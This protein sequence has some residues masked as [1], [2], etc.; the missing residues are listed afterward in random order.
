[1]YA[2]RSPSSACSQSPDYQDPIKTLESDYKQERERLKRTTDNSPSFTL[3]SSPLTDP[4]P[5]AP[6]MGSHL[7]S[8]FSPST[9]SLGLF[10]SP[11]FARVC[12]SARTLAFDD[13]RDVAAGTIEIVNV[14]PCGG[15]LERFGGG[16]R[17]GIWGG[18]GRL[19][20]GMRNLSEVR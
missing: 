2:S 18:T 1:M 19:Q 5:K 7:T 9:S 10:P 16:G 13:E 8:N 4:I 12:N 11:N 14:P 6:L 3:T 17:P 15:N 20:N